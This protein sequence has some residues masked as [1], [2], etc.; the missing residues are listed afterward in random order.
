MPRYGATRAVSVRK[1]SHWDF[2]A[3][4]DKAAGVELLRAFVAG[5]AT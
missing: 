3:P 5:D 1:F 4:D 2:T